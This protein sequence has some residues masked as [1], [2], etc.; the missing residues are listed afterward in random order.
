MTRRIW[1]I[2]LNACLLSPGL[3]AIARAHQLQVEPVAVVIRPQESYLNAEFSGNVQDITQIP[4]QMI[5]DSQR[6]G[7]GFTREA[8]KSVEAYLNENFLLRRN[9][10]TLTGMLV[11][12]RHESGLDPTRARFKIVLRYPL[13]Q[14]AGDEDRASYA[15]T[16]HLFNYLPNALTTV[17]VAGF[18]RN[19]KPGDSTTVE[20]GALAAN[21]LRNV[22]DFLILGAVHI[23]EGIDHILF[24]LALLLVSTSLKSLVKTLT[25]F[26]IAHSLTLVLSTLSV[27]TL[28]MRLV[29]ILV[30]LSI[31]YVG[32]ENLFLKTTRHRFWIASAF[33]LVHGFA[34][35]TNLREAGLPE[36]NAL[37]WSLL[38]FNIGVEMAQV[39]ICLAAFPLLMA[40]KKST[41]H[42]QKYGGMPWQSVV[43]TASLGVVIAGSY[44]LM[45]R[46]IG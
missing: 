35:A 6:V 11:T 7:D 21:L 12:L 13:P 5:S 23:F 42:R 8:Q 27:I 43:R 36:G 17:N 10:E 26:T 37:F 15:I 18:Q 20:P 2:I 30:A 39:V 40:W 45:Q 31:V 44:W 1:L 16:S 38:S 33:G 4:G 34:F 32:A 14:A 46:L 22:R 25:G 24:I 29:D 3:C 41:E 19:L 28:P 9:G